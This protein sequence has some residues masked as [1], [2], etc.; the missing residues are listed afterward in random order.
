MSFL[1]LLLFLLLVCLHVV[2]HQLYHVFALCTPTIVVIRGGGRCCLFCCCLCLIAVELL[3]WFSG[4]F[5]FW[6]VVSFSFSFVVLIVSVV[7]SSGMDDGGGA[8]STLVYSCVLN[9]H[10]FFLFPLDVWFSLDDIFFHFCSFLSVGCF[11]FFSLFHCWCIWF[12]FPSIS[13]VGVCEKACL[14]CCLEVWVV[15]SRWL[16]FFPSHWLCC[17]SLYC[18]CFWFVGPRELSLKNQASVAWLATQF[19][20]SVRR[21]NKKPDARL[22]YMD[23]LCDIM[24][25]ITK[26]WRSYLHADKKSWRTSIL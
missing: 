23:K 15:F 11:L 25:F 8:S 21:G 3:L 14:L 1:Y 22:S 19:L 16:C 6:E 17:L 9:F 24:H 10:N 26:Y 2:Q 12:C 20:L 18:C 7:I 4:L 13:V 5:W